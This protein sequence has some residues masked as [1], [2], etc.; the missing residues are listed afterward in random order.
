[1]TAAA[2]SARRSFYDFGSG[3]LDHG[4]FGV[5]PEDKCD[6]AAPTPAHSLDYSR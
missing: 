3:E 5:A 1:M 4:W 2:S 6:A